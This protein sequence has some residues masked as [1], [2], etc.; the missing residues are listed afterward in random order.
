[1]PYLDSRLTTVITHLAF[2]VLTTYAAYLAILGGSAIYLGILFGLWCMYFLARSTVHPILCYILFGLITTV[3]FYA[4]L[5]HLSLIWVLLM[6][7]CIIL[8]FKCKQQ[9][10]P[11]NSQFILIFLLIGLCIF[12][13][14]EYQTLQQLKQHYASFDTGETWQKFGAL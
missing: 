10:I 1:M 4:L 8:N 2:A 5:S 14:D 9:T 7:A 13:Y 11:P 6:H 3:S 12:G